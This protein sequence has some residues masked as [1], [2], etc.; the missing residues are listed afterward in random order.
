MKTEIAVTTGDFV[1]VS[2]SSGTK[3][4]LL[5][6][7]G[8]V[9]SL[10][11]K[12]YSK[13]EDGRQAMQKGALAEDEV[14]R[15]RLL[16]E[17]RADKEIAA[18]Q[19]PFSQEEIDSPTDWQAY[20]AQLLLETLSDDSL[21]IRSAL[22]IGCYNDRHFSYMAQKFPDI[23]FCSVDFMSAARLKD[24]NALLPQSPNWS[25]KSGYPLKLLMTKEVSGDLV[26][27]SST[28][29][30]FNNKELDLYLDE[31]C[32]QSRVI[33]IN[34]GWGIVSKT[35]R[36]RSLLTLPRII[37]PEEIPEEEPVVRSMD[38]AYYFYGHNY[39]RKLEKR[40]FSIRSSKIRS[41]NNPHLYLYQLVAVKA[42]YAATNN[43]I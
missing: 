33:V 35:S 40:G 4:K 17:D 21:G 19:I 12:I 20:G 32:E 8:M 36:V 7:I 27:L 34:E 41:G 23:K 30:L 14:E 38:G 10:A 9:V 31:I 13:L 5:L 3:Y 11:T 1:K 29:L 24:F 26:F 43:A 28:S 22:N 39:I 16:C 37:R 2:L 18:R 15:I 25:L 6:L 42:H